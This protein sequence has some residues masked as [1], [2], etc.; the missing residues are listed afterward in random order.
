MEKVPACKDCS[1]R[2]INTSARKEHKVT[3]CEDDV[4]SVKYF[5]YKRHIVYSHKCLQKRARMSLFASFATLSPCV[6]TTTQPLDVDKKTVAFAMDAA[7]AAEDASTLMTQR[8]G[9]RSGST[10]SYC[11]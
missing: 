1:I 11:G 9:M 5:V 6:T 2:N 10:P 4:S 3:A 8:D 7:A